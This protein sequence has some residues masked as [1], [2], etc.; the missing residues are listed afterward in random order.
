MDEF[1]NVYTLSNGW[2]Y[3][4]IYITEL[5]NSFKHVHYLLIMVQLWCVGVFTTNIW[6]IRRK[7]FWCYNGGVLLQ[8]CYTKV[9]L[10]GLLYYTRDT[11]SCHASFLCR[12]HCSHWG[13]WFYTF[14]F[15]L[16][17]AFLQH[18]IQAI[19]QILHFLNACTHYSGFLNRGL[20]RLHCS[21]ATNYS[22]RENLSNLCKFVVLPVTQE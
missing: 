12:Y 22:W 17:H 15:Y 11:H 9:A 8:K 6:G 10:E 21:C 20:I 3:L 19:S 4:C 16:S 13:L 2:I 14:R 18:G 7:S 1:I 5:M